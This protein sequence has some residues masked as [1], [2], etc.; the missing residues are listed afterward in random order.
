MNKLAFAATLTASGLMLTATQAAVLNVDF[1]PGAAYFGDNT[2]A[3][4][5]GILTGDQ[6]FIG[7]NGDATVTGF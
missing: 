3:N 4:A 1:G 7:V 5:A 2:P 6:T